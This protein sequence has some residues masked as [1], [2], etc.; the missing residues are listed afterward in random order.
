MST[1]IISIISIS[2]SGNDFIRYPRDSCTYG[3]S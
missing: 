2:T 3:R 1:F